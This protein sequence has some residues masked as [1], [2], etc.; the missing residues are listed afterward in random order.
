MQSWETKECLHRSP[1]FVLSSSLFAF[2]KARAAFRVEQLA[3]VKLMGIRKYGQRQVTPS[4][5]IMFGYSCLFHF[6][7]GRV[8]VPAIRVT[9]Q[10]NLFG[11]EVMSFV[12]F[13]GMRFRQN[14]RGLSMYSKPTEIYSIFKVALPC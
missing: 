7:S 4:V 13:R 14:L 10:G 6:E 11:S 3:C 2:R 1:C 12:A 9:F 8:C 5:N